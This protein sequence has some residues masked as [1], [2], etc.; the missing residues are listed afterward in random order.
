MDILLGV[1]TEK[2]VLLVTSRSLARGVSVLKADDVKVTECNS[3]TAMAFSGEPG[4]TVNFIE[5]I[6]ANVQ[7]YSFRHSTELSTTAVASFARQEL[8]KS[9]RTRKP[10][11]VNLL[12][13]GAENGKPELH[14]IDYLGTN[15]SLPYAAHGYASYYVLSTLDRW[16]K[17]TLTLEQGVDL[18]NKCLNE[19][20]MRLPIDFK[21]CDIHVVN[22]EGTRLYE[23]AGPSDASTSAPQPSQPT[24]VS[25]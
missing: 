16:W 9:L 5:Y 4:D 17:P 11:Q 13:A 12:V 15:V 2:E 8:A 22:E 23:P 19:L 21:G 14:W 20:T 18:V 3:R 25:S 1:R 7:L 24:A 6:K 10:Y